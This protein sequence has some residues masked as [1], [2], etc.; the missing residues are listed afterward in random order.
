M[1]LNT[2]ILILATVLF[3]G[4]TH[5]GFYLLITGPCDDNVKASLNGT[6]FPFW[7]FTYTPLDVCI[8]KNP[9]NTQV[10]SGYYI[11]R[12]SDTGVVSLNP[13]NDDQ[14]LDCST[15]I[16]ADVLITSPENYDICSHPD[17]PTGALVDDINGNNPLINNFRSKDGWRFTRAE[18]FPLSTEG[19]CSNDSQFVSASLSPINP[20]NCSLI[21]SANNIYTKSVVT[22]TQVHQYICPNDS[23]CKVCKEILP[24]FDVLPSG[25]CVINTGKTAYD[26]FFISQ[27]DDYDPN[28]ATYSGPG[29][30]SS[31]N[32]GA[33]FSVNLMMQFT[34]GL[35]LM[36][37]LMI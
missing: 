22:T 9:N 20:G 11:Y 34:L 17:R 13:C 8:K 30:S 23:S 25:T 33:G 19:K 21:N 31:S 35:S 37:L 5:A 26:K 27:V 12:T 32:S 6:K 15:P 14:C 3:I 7:K 36:I 24:P 29:G 2:F 16:G 18:V 4:S 1:S 10:D 28:R